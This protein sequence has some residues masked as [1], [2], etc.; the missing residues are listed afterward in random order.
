MPG[1]GVRTIHGISWHDNLAW[2]E[3]MK[4]SRWNSHILAEQ[5]RWKRALVP[6]QDTIKILEDELEAA[7]QT[8]HTMLFRSGGGAIE[9]GMAGSM[10]VSWKLKGKEKIR[11]ATT[12]ET[13]HDGSVVWTIEEVGDGA[14]L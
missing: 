4:G 6:L 14:E 5:K 7:S 12:L 1:T 10:T 13:N 11:T 8:F 2:M 9:I 3:N